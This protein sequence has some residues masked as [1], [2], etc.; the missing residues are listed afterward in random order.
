MKEAN[1]LWG[2]LG[3]VKRYI[4]PISVVQVLVLGRERKTKEKGGHYKMKSDTAVS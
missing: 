2:K 3:Y 4:S 1:L